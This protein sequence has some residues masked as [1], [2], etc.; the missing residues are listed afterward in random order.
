M[1]VPGDRPWFK[2][3]PEGVPR[4]IDYPEIPLFELLTGTARKYPDRVA[5]T[6]QGS[7]LTY[8]DLDIATGKLAAGLNDYGVKKGDR[9]LLLLGNS[10]E[11]VT[12]YYAI[13][14]A[15]ATVVPTNPLYKGREL[16]HHLNDSEAVAII[17]SREL[18]PTVKEIRDETGLKTAVLTDA[19]GVTGTV[20]LA[21]ILAHYSPAP[22]EL[23]INT[24]EDVAAIEYTGGTTGLPKGV[25]LTHYNLVANALQ[26]AAWFGWNDK[27]V[28]IGVLPFY[29]SWGA[30][31]CV[32][33]AVYA[34]ARVVIF[35]RFS[36]QEL[37]ETIEREK[38]T[39]IYG[40]ASLFTM[41]TTSPLITEYDLSSLRYIKAGAMPIPPEIKTRWERSPA[42]PWFWATA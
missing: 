19:E 11:F 16:K 25:M 12:G 5:Y 3:W 24:K 4:H 29:H 7:S 37:L 8:H 18:Y 23:D 42:L 41:L 40:A 20:A 22:V 21:E 6:C 15:G 2:F 34:G 17:T 9:V 35:P 39:V 28:V 32:I 10:L 31:T 27:D 26:N 36:A 14:K 30:S 33:S 38:A 13:L 1:Q